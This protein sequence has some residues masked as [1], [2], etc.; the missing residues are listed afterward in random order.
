MVMVSSARWPASSFILL[1]S[2]ARS[3]LPGWYCLTGSFTGTGV[4]ET[5]SFTIAPGGSGS[6]SCGYPYRYTPARRLV[7]AGLFGQVGQFLRGVPAEFVALGPVHGELGVLVA[8]GG[9]GQRVGRRAHVGSGVGVVR[10][11]RDQQ[12]DGDGGGDQHPAGLVVPGVEL[13]LLGR[14]LG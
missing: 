14:D 3:W 1:S 10:V 5:A 9:R 2:A 12:R 7:R 6:V 13:G 11:R 8:R 4:L